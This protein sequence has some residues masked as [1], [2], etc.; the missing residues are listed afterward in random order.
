M[1][2]YILIMNLP[3]EL[4]T[5]TPLSKIMSIITFVALIFA[6]FSLGIGYQKMIEYAK[7]QEYNTQLLIFN[8]QPT[9]TIS[10][11]DSPSP[12]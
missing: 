4:T 3:K 1:A 2:N 9:P 5:V 7:R 12:R 10:V 11:H 6:G 8:R